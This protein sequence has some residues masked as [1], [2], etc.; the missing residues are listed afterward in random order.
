MDST[1]CTQPIWVGTPILHMDPS[2][3]GVIPEQIA[4]SSLGCGV[5]TDVAPK[6]KETE[7]ELVC[8]P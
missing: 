5:T 6:Q 3:S 2:T 1:L 8:V 7:A 4:R